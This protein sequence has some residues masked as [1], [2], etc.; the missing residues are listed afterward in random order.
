MAIRIVTDSSC[1]LPQ[2]LVDRYGIVVL[3]FYINVGTKS[4]LDG[5]D[6]SR[7]EFYERL[8]S[9]PSS[10]TTSVPG[11]GVLVD[12][13][14]KL[15]TEGATHILSIHV[16]ATLSAMVN[17]ARL[18]AAELN[19]VPVTV[20]DS[21]NLTV[22]TGVQA[23]AAAQAAARGQ[24]VADIVALLDGMARRTHCIAGLDTLEYLRR[25][26][27]LSR[28]Q[29]GLGAALRIKPVLKMNAGEIEMERVRTRRRAMER[30]VE[31][32]EALGPLQ[33]LVLVH[34]HA[35]E[36][37]KELGERV[38][39]LFPA[40]ASALSAEVTP[41]IGSHIGPGAVGFVAVQAAG[42]QSSA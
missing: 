17:T 26:G 16:S 5:I 35:P 27:R 20:I 4:Y 12:L 25:S 39:H 24:S 15:A 21:G 31:L 40:H 10:P 41:V 8:P 9:F 11:P 38:R 23:V 7:S 1:D 29:W 19:A 37:A 34:T 3:P 13:Y 33:D 36:R 30:V 42:E 6:I 2:E 22:G 28:F 32:V 18:A 14:G